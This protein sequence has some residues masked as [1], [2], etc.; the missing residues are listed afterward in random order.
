MPEISEKDLIAGCRKNNRTFQ[1]YLYKKYYSLFLKVCSRYA[2]DMQDAEQLMHDGF[3]KIFNHI[4]DFGSRGSFEGWMR[5]IMVNTCLDYLKSKYVKNSMQLYFS[6]D[7]SEDPKLSIQNNA[8]DKMALKNLLGII[9]TLPPMS[10]MVFNLFVFEGYSHKEI[11][12]LLEIS[13]GTSQWHVNNARKNLQQ[14]INKQETQENQEKKTK[15][16]EQK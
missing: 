11:S 9:Q 10:K 6:Q 14:K 12:Q 13:E 15:I 5:R 7:M 8:L 1:E 2:R 16:Y 4:H 3:I